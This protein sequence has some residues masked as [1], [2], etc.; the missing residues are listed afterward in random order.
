MGEF[1]DDH[2]V[3]YA[4]GTFRPAQPQAR[5]FSICRSNGVVLTLGNPGPDSELAETL[6]VLLLAPE[7]GKIDPPGEGH[8]RQIRR[9]PAFDN[10][11]DDSW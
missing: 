8:N 5:N 7:Q 4:A 9:L 10:C 2:V 3:Y 11:F 1:V 6:Q